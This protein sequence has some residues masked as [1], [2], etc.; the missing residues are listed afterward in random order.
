MKEH[1]ILFSAPMVRAILAGRKTVTRRVLK[2]QP[3]INSAGLLL[4]DVPRLSLQGD[5]DMIAMHQKW[6]RGDRLW[7]RE[8]HYLTDDG[9]NELVVYAEDEAAV[10]EHLAEIAAM[11][12]RDTRF[13]LSSHRRLRPSIHMPRWA[14]RITLEVTG[15]KVERLQDIS[16]EDAMAEGLRLHQSFGGAEWYT[17][18]GADPRKCGYRA[19]TAY[20]HL[21]TTINGPG[22]WDANPWVVAVAFKRVEV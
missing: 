11:E 18:D 13:D 20:Q 2:P 21:W 8:A 9:D 17:F 3:R 4:W 7:V 12:E 19:V 22:S 16:E 10:K 1:P 14:S 5:A 15:V 6:Q